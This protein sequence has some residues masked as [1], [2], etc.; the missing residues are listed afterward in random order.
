MPQSFE[1]ARALI[2]AHIAPL[3]GETVPLLDAVGRVLEREF[4]APYDL[5]RFA[6][7]AMDGYALRAADARPGARLRVTGYIP[8]G[9]RAEPAV[10]VG[11]AVR[12]MTGAPI[13]PGG[14]TVIPVEETDGG[15]AEVVLQGSATPGDHIR[16]RGEDIST[17]SLV[18]AAGTLLRPAEISLLASCGRTR[19]SVHR[20]PKV[21]ILSTG[22]ELVEPGTELSPETIVDSNSWALAAAVREVGAEPALLGIARDNHASLREKLRLGLTADAL[23]TSAGVSAGDRDLVREVLEELGVRPLFWKIDIKPGR[24]TAFGLAGKIPV[25]SLPGNPVSSLL[26]FDTFV[27]P[28]LLKMLGHRQVLRPLLQAT[29][30]APVAKKA[31]R[32]HFLRVRVGRVNGHLTA[33]SAGDQNTGILS[34]LLHANGVAV[35]PA[36][37]EN[38]AAGETVD[39]HLFEPELAPAEA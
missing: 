28:A 8:A 29:L 14:D 11:C 34:T 35:L 33:I 18:L 3:T 13:P 26:T 38:F 39:I 23:I 17:G 31:G 15:L 20:R 6:N 27:R 10:A 1:N 12:I 9:G 22:D 30:Q 7:S 2:L 32:V 36:E 16:R 37:R 21:A 25:F 4:A 24:P 5:P 19:V